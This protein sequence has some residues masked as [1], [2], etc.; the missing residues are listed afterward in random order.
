MATQK[1]NGLAADLAGIN[2]TSPLVLQIDAGRNK[3][4]TT[5]QDFSCKLGRIEDL[6]TELDS[7]RFGCPALASVTVHRACVQ[8]VFLGLEAELK[9]TV[10]VQIGE[11]TMLSSATY[12]VAVGVLIEHSCACPVSSATMCMYDG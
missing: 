11:S 6:V 5:T 4:A 9:F 2:N 3:L 8:L 12:P 1:W 7:L 10:Q